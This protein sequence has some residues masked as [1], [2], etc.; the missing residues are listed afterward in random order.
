MTTAT[1]EQN[2]SKDKIMMEENLMKYLGSCTRSFLDEL[3][4]TFN[5]EEALKLYQYAHSI[6]KK[7]DVMY[8]TITK[9]LEKGLDQF[10]AIKEFHEYVEGSAESVKEAQETMKSYRAGL[11]GK[12]NDISNNFE[13]N[14]ETRD[15]QKEILGK[16]KCTKLI[17]N[18]LKGYG[19]AVVAGH[20][21]GKQDQVVTAANYIAVEASQI[22]KHQDLSD[23]SLEGVKKVIKNVNTGI[24]KLVA[25]LHDEEGNLNA[26][27]N[28]LV[29]ETVEQRKHMEDKINAFVPQPVKNK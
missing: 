20:V 18:G 12:V 9:D 5:D 23:K 11:Q 22:V 26:K 19:K 4:L 29:A 16:L 6:K 17:E 13:I 10:N 2:Q 15:Y 27:V 28:S 21:I 3:I 8:Q 24:N 14:E 1:K 7:Q 25:T